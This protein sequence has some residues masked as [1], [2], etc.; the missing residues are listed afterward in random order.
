SGFGTTN[1]APATSV[2]LNNPNGLY[3]FENGMFYI[4]DRDNGLI[5]KVDTE[6]TM[7]TMVNQGSGISGGRGLWVSPDESL[8]YYCNGS[9]LMQWDSTNGLVAFVSGFF[10]LG[11]IAMDPTGHL[12][13]TDD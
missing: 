6:A 2:P 3:V 7:T 10:A 8:L 4:L 9:T 13:V 11:N 5:R 1:P 12:V